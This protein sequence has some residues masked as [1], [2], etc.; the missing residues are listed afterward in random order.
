MKMI[1][2]QSFHYKTTKKCQK[3]M[4]YRENIGQKKLSV[5]HAVV[6]LNI[7]AQFFFSS[8]SLYDKIFTSQ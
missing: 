3:S 2:T 7:D 5:E 8:L 1:K 6:A 4:T